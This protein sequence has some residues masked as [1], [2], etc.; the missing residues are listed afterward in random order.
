VKVG[1]IP[2]YALYPKGGL[3]PTTI[4][5]RKIQNRNVSNQ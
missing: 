5:Y 1:E 4:Y 3:C 2:D